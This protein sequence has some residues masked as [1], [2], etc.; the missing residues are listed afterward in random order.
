MSP[1]QQLDVLKMLIVDFVTAILIR[2]GERI[3]KTFTTL[4]DVAFAVIIDV[5]RDI[6]EDEAGKVIAK[7]MEKQA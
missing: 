6:A 5:K 1:E 4:Q 7:A 3:A 2:D